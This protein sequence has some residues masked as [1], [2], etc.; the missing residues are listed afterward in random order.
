MFLAR[1]CRARKWDIKL[2][3]EMFT[4]YVKYRHEN[5]IDTISGVGKRYLKT[6]KVFVHYIEAFI[7][8][9]SNFVY[10]IGASYYQRE[11]TSNSR[12]SWK[13]ILWN[14]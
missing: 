9:L 3:T 8:Q 13:R 10:D 2:M 5:K 14:R 11:I 7:L 1:F 12:M 6:L 4:N